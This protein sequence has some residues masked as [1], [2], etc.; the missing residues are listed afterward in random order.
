MKPFP[1]NLPVKRKPNWPFLIYEEQKKLY[2]NPVVKKSKYS[3]A[4]EV[5]EALL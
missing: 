1:K 2:L 5:G 3:E 4:K